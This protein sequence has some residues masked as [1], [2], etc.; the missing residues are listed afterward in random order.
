MA[1]S[2]RCQPLRYTPKPSTILMIPERR[3]TTRLTTVDLQ[4]KSIGIVV[5][6]AAESLDQFPIG[7]MFKLT[8][9][10]GADGTRRDVSRSSGRKTSRRT[11]P[12]RPE[13]GEPSIYFEGFGS[14]DVTHLKPE[15]RSEAFGFTQRSATRSSGQAR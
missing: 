9:Q 6:K 12:R 13:P 3:S 2:Y 5:G 11:Q 10:N 15:L 7:R 14:P 4:A 1:T 8:L